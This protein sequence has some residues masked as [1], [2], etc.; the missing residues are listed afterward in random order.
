MRLLTIPISHYCERARWALDR[1]GIEYRE[2]QHIQ[3][4][5]VR[6][7]RKLSASS[8]VPILQTTQGEVLDES[9]EIVR[10]AAAHAASD[11][12]PLYPVS[13]AGRQEVESVE[14][15][16]EDRL[17][18]ATRRVIYWN[19]LRW[20]RAG[21]RFNRADAPAWEHNLLW[22]LFPLLRPGFFRSQGINA[23]SAAAARD[24]VLA[25]FD[26]AA[27]R[28]G[29]REFLVGDS[30]TAADLTFACMA[31]PVVVPEHYG[32]PL[33]RMDEADENTAAMMQEFR[34]HPAG[35]FAM[36]MFARERN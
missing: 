24:E 33:P 19:L 11:R 13:A 10:Y 32:V 28:L 36:Q 8:S 27:A 14:R 1:A 16:F 7:A 29:D 26:A 2:E 6:H 17:G 4:F 20:G 22:L 9:A 25:L 34:A 3:F 15:Q 18:R 5:H 12:A 23:A 30:F 31:A 35:A 21:L